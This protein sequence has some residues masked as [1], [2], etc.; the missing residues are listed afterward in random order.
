LAAKRLV[1]DTKSSRLRAIGVPTSLAKAVADYHHDLASDRVLA[2]K[3]AGPW[4][5]LDPGADLEV[6]L[7]Q[8]QYVKCGVGSETNEFAKQISEHYASQRASLEARAAEFAAV[9][10]ERNS[11]HS[12]HALVE[13][14][15]FPWQAVP[16]FKP[17]EKLQTFMHLIRT[18]V[19]DQRICMVPWR[20]Q[21]HWI[22]CVI[23]HLM[24]CML[25]PSDASVHTDL[26]AFLQSGHHAAL[27]QAPIYRL[28]P[29]DALLVPFGS[30]PVFLAVEYSNQGALEIPRRSKKTVR[31]IKDYAA[32]TVSLAFDKEKDAGRPVE[33]QVFVLSQFLAGL[34]RM[35]STTR[36]SEG[37]EAR[38]KQLQ[39]AQADKDGKQ[40]VVT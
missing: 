22:Q 39:A 5:A 18:Y 12:H 20:A 14:P 11:D 15:E 4:D 13:G 27:T 10:I 34:P 33:T 29:G 9:D 23:G 36:G 32:Y 38:R 40:E 26:D 8:A 28:E 21:R 6:V 31:E 7:N 30:V 17:V 1:R 2:V 19:V 35:G 37:V 24:I 16:F 3:K 25:P